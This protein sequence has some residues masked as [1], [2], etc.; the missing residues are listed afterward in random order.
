MNNVLALIIVLTISVFAQTK[1]ELTGRV[2]DESGYP[3]PGV[4]I[5]LEDFG[6]ATDDTG[7]FKISA[8]EGGVYDIKF[9]AVGFETKILENVELISDTQLNIVMNEKTILFDAVVVTAGKHEQNLKELPVSAAVMQSREIERKN[10][11]NLDDALRYI[12]GVSMTLDQV[13]IRGSSGY[14]RGAGTRV[15]VAL[16]GIPM[17]TGD[18]GEII[19]EVFP[20]PEIERIEVI[21]GAASSLYGSS[22]IGGVVNVL[23]KEPGKT[24]LTFLRTYGGF[25]D[26]PSN[27][28]WEWSDDTRFFNGLTVGHSNN[29]NDL[30]YAVSLTRTEDMGYRQG[31]WRKRYAGYLKMNYQFGETDNLTLLANGYMQ[32]K[33]TFNFW[34]NLNNALVP[35]DADQGQR[36]PSERFLT[37]II[38]NSELTQKLKFTNRLSFYHSFWKDGS[39]SLNSSNSKQ[40]RNELQFDYAASENLLFI[41]GVEVNYATVNA[42][43]FGINNA[44]GF[45]LFLHG[46]YKLNEPVTLTA[47]V[48][49]DYHKRKNINQESAFSPKFGINYKL[50]EDLSARFFFGTGFRAPSV[51]ET[52]T[53]TTTSGL[54]I[55]PNQNLSSET[56]YSVETGV[57]FTPADFLELDAA[58]FYN[59]YFDLIETTIDTTNLTEPYVYFDNVTNARI[60]G[61]DFSSGLKFGDFYLKT[62]YTFLDTEDLDEGS[63]LKYRPKHLLYLSATY[64]YDI[65]EAGVDFRYSSRVDEIDDELIDFGFVADGEKRVETRTVDLRFSAALFRYNIPGRIGLNIYNL[66]NYN[67]VEMIANVSPIRNISLNLDLLM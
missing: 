45:G 36:I 34:K 14:S 30:G 25:Y 16:D 56:N 62:G 61:F 58:L 17:Y 24:P 6:A 19:W 11:I 4:N 53:S 5:L 22:A 12:P 52:F 57:N 51:A 59:R 3:I 28:Q 33:G 35:P 10:F 1:V 37:G 38:Y 50:S 40:I 43:I 60:A 13:S 67:Y 2:T 7:K 44:Y 66:F 48:R 39:E 64:R 26:K 21:K 55:R 9:S 42:N 54:T 18:S 8:I 15:L 29:I 46:D 63:F 41:S 49:Y 32:D 20:M 47:G 65:F 31:D 23:T 27:E